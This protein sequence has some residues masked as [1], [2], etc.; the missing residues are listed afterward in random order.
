[1]GAEA[2]QSPLTVWRVVARITF[3]SARTKEGVRSGQQDCA[4]EIE[5]RQMFLQWMTLSMTLRL[6]AY[7][8]YSHAAVQRLDDIWIIPETFAMQTASWQDYHNT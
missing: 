6:S 3:Q 8:V 7:G 4:A 2:S 1:M 5:K